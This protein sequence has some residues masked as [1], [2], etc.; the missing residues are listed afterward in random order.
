MPSLLRVTIPVL[1]VVAACGACPAQAASV[2]FVIVRPASFHRGPVVQTGIASWYGAAWRGRRTASGARFNPDAM[3]A[4]SRTLPLGSRVLVTLAGSARSVL[5]TIT[6]RLGAAS[7]V[8][9]LSRAAA[10]RIGLLERGTARV[11]LRRA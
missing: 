8:I 1:A 9:D 2:S 11:V 4:A 6:D 10:L 3:T 5:V 7:R